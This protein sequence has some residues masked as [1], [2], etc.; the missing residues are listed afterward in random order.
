VVDVDA[1]VTDAE[2]VQAVALGGEIL[3][4]CSC[5]SHQEFIHPFRMALSGTHVKIPTSSRRDRLERC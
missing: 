4:L 1:I 2:G 3:L 5:V